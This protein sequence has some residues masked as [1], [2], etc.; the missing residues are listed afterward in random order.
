MKAAPALDMVLFYLSRSGGG[1]FREKNLLPCVFGGNCFV[2][3]YCVSKLNSHGASTQVV[4]YCTRF[5][6]LHD[7][8]SCV[9]VE[10]PRNHAEAMAL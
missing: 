1:F 5:F 8:F 3:V 6:H 7:N 4:Y 9:V 2:V 10:N